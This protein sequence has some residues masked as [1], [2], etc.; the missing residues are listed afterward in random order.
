MDLLH[1]SLELVV[2]TL[3]SHEEFCQRLLISWELNLLRAHLRAVR[4]NLP[5]ATAQLFYKRNG[6]LNGLV[7]VGS[8]DDTRDGGGQRRA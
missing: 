2:V 7:A 5:R 4:E 8:H 3:S 6:G 1:E